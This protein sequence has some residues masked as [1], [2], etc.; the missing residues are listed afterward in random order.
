VIV[1]YK[2]MKKNEMN[3]TSH[4]F[5]RYVYKGVWKIIRRV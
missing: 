2:E 3:W 1:E 5:R 4:F